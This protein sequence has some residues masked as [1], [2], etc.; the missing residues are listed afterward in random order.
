MKTTHVRCVSGTVA[1]VAFGE[2]PSFKIPHEDDERVIDVFVVESPASRGRKTSTW[3]WTATI[4][5]EPA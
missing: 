2:R 3:Y 5:K 4:I 1:R